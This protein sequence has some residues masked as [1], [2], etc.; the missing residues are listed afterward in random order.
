[1]FG[2]KKE[3]VTTNELQGVQEVKKES[4]IIICSF[5]LQKKE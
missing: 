3:L 5:F 4:C 1:M 2:K